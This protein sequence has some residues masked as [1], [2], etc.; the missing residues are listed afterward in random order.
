MFLGSFIKGDASFELAD[1][2]EMDEEMDEGMA[3]QVVH[4][5]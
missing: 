5:M 3:E 2:E 4:L 1:E